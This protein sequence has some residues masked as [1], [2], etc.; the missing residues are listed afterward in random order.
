MGALK[1]IR[2]R[3]IQAHKDVLI[4]FPETG[5]VVFNGE[6]SHGKSVIRKVIE[7]TLF[8]NL[9]NPTVRRSLVTRRINEGTCEITKYDG[10]SLLININIE[11]SRTFVRLTRADGT[12]HT[13]YLAD[14][15][16]PELM[17]EFGFHYDSDHG[18]SLNICDSDTDILFFKTKHSTNGSVLN[19]ALTDT[20]AQGK[21]DALRD[22]YREAISMRQ[23]FT[24]N[25]RV[26]MAAKS[27]IQLYDVDKEQELERN[28]Q[29]MANILEHV[30][31][32]RLAEAQPIPMVMY[33]NVPPIR[34]ST[35]KMPLVVNVP[36]V[37]LKDVTP[38]WK[39]LESLLK[40]VCPTCG[41]PL[42]LCQTCTNEM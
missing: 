21:A 17:E 42:F 28:A 19:T 22:S 2:T 25:L 41:R 5:L 15:T 16:I 26:A 14:K 34:V 39:E 30:Y 24:E 36:P 13:R 1:S 18:I 38:M 33:V 31:I 3:N 35:F 6:N 8:G 4:S 10:S 7:D 11:A 40:G 29:Y 20:R 12:E 32:P 27:A 9:R 37:R 23:T